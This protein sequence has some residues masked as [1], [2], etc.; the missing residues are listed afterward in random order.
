MRLKKE[1]KSITLKIGINEYPFPPLVSIICAGENI[2]IQSE[3]VKPKELHYE[4]SS[5]SADYNNSY[6]NNVPFII[7]TYQDI[8]TK[9]KQYDWNGICCISEDFEVNYIR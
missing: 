1:L 4:L 2:E 9:L 7:E 8:I 3:F 5:I 6:S